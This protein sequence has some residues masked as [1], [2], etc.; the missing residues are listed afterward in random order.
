MQGRILAKRWRL[1]SEL[2]KGDMGSV[3]RAEHVELSTPAAVKLI[4]PMIADSDEALARFKR[5]AQ[6]AAHDR[7]SR[8]ERVVGQGG[9]GVFWLRRGRSSINGLSKP[10]DPGEASPIVGTMAPGSIELP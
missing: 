1:L 8:I 5:E 10:G 7:S 3:W 4:D 2:G 9:V 6:A